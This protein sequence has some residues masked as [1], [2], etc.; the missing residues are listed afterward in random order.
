MDDRP[1]RQQGAPSAGTYQR[2]VGGASIAGAS[3]AQ[4]MPPPAPAGQAAAPPTEIVAE[5]GVDVTAYQTPIDIVETEDEV[6]VLADVPGYRTEDIEIEATES[7]VRIIAVRADA[8]VEE[9]E[10]VYRERPDRIDRVVSLPVPLDLERSSA[11]YEEGVLRVILPKAT[12]KRRR[13]IGI[14]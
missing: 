9:G 4:P 11:V 12:G 1:R 14:H 13:T 3:P 5:P 2:G 7:S 8:A 6:H 10:T